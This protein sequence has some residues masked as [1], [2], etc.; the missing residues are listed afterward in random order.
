MTTA[1]ARGLVEEA[2]ASAS[3]KMNER[4]TTIPSS[5]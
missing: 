3:M 1:G 2:M 4:K 5:I